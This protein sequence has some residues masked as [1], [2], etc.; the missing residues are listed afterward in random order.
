MRASG[1]GCHW[2]FVV[3]LY[4]FNQWDT[5]TYLSNEKFREALALAVNRGEIRDFIFDG[6]G[7]IIGSGPAYGTWATGY[8]PV[9]LVPYNPERAKQ[10]VKEAFPNEEPFINI[11]VWQTGGVPETFTIGEALAGYFEKIGVKSKIIPTEYSTVR[12]E[13]SRRPL[14]NNEQ[15]LPQ[16]LTQIDN[17]LR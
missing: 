9:P 10:L 11:Y 8:K 14:H 7:E 3:G 13:M 4:I 5:T 12:K 1:Y 6:K 17:L 2:E 16:F 15:R